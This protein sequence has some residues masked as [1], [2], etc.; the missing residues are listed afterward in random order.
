MMEGDL[1]IW[2]VASRYEAIKKRSFGTSEI[3]EFQLN[4]EI[5]ENGL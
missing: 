2:L 3:S 5:E 4:S 1:W